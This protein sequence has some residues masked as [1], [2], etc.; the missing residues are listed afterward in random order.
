[1]EHDHVPVQV[2]V[3]KPASIDTPFFQHSRSKTGVAPK[4]I[5][6]VYDPQL[7]A[8][9]V[10]YAATHA[11]RVLTIGGFA[12]VMQASETTMPGMLDRE[13]AMTGFALQESDTPDRQQPPDNLFAP[14]PGA[15]S[16]RGGWNGRG[17]SLYTWLE[18]H[19]GVRRAAAASAALGGALLGG[20]V[21][22]NRFE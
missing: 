6:P 17:A 15:G 16:I 19:P 20:A 9:A 3:I 12:A 1:M 14:S 2:T 11:A 13:L 5:P 21:V 10:L 4:P 7:V 18:L 22:R 8:D